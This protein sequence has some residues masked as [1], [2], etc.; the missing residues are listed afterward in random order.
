MVIFYSYVKLPNGNER[1][2]GKT[3][4]PTVDEGLSKIATLLTL[5]QRPLTPM[6]LKHI[7]MRSRISCVCVCVCLCMCVC[8]CLTYK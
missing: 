1:N 7:L 6:S 5:E 3:N 2:P 4:I 8:V